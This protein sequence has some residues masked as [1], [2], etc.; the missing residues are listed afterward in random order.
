MSGSYL[1]DVANQ[2]LFLVCLS[3]SLNLLLGFA[4]Q[5]SMATAAF[6]GIGAYACGIMTAHGQTLT[7]TDVIGP[8]WPFWGGLVAA[9]A[10]S[11][12]SGMVI[13]VPAARRVLGD[14][15]ILLT[16]AFQ[17]LVVTGASSW[18][19][20]TGG[21]NGMT[22][23]PISFAGI[24]ITT[25][26]QA[27]AWLLG[28]TLVISA[29]C[30]FI[31]ASPYG[32]L[33]RG[34]RED[35][36]MVQALG[37]GTIWPKSLTFG[38]TAAVAGGIGA[39]SAAYTQFVAPTTYSL[40]LAILVVACVALGGPG[41]IVG[42]AMA[43][44]IIGGLRPFL[45]GVLGLSDE[46]SLPWQ[47]IIYGVVIVLG[48]RFRPMG[49]LPETLFMR[50]PKMNV[51]ATPRGAPAESVRR[52]GAGATATSA[53]VLQVRGISKT[54]GSIHAAQAVSFD[55]H[56]G[57]IVALIGPNGAGKTTVFNLLTGAIPADEGEVRLKGQNIT[58]SHPV[59]IAQAGMLRFF[60][61]VRLFAGITA[62]DNVALAVPHQTGEALSRLVFTPWG[63]RRR[64]RVVRAE[65]MRQLEFCGVADLAGSLVRDLA[66]GQQ[67][68]IALAR[69][70]AS[71]GDVLLLDEPVSG[72]DPRSAE[73]IIALVLSLARSGK[74]ICIV[75]HSLHV[76][77]ELADRV[78]FMNAGQ[79]VA[80]GTVEA[81]TSR[82]DLIDLY[83]GM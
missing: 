59:S 20:L 83:F 48:M 63:A 61:N 39:I 62:L 8:G 45:E 40:D 60:Q 71:G 4:G 5:M 17:F 54:L 69:L 51:D 67:K 16:L 72:V 66:F 55:L 42:S 12:V 7:G 65:A 14:Y 6:F 9:V 77:S 13:A 25:T 3:V 46:N 18:V 10:A 47:A 21:P 34:I 15:L 64:E 28:L 19:G 81:I 80:E 37:K 22:V 38:L 76:V 78:V 41:N 57:E 23:P 50:R 32:R 52:D 43:A 35:E 44:I 68:L 75:E 31:G 29:G 79:V 53:P 49:L 70:L 27:F 58:R 30:W 26:D 82:A 36:L 1:A 11:F 56:A 73:Q 24:D 33:L 74:A 2:V